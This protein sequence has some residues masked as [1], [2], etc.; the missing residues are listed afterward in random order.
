M[1][2]HTHPGPRPSSQSKFP[3]QVWLAI[4][5]V[6][7]ILID[8]AMSRHDKVDMANTVGFYA[9]YGFAA[10]AFVVIMGHPLGKLLR[11]DE[12]FYGDQDEDEEEGA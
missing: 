4:A 12:N 7:L 10:F 1:H 3:I 8:L 2:S 11:R 6:V 5:S 9:V